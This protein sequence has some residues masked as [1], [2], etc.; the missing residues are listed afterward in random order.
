MNRRT[1]STWKVSVIGFILT[2]LALAGCGGGGGS[3]TS[4]MTTV[5]GSVSTVD[6]TTDAVV[7]VTAPTEVTLSIPA[8]TTLTDAS[9]NPVSGTVPTSVGYSTS[10]KDLPAAATTLPAG[11]ALAVF[12]DIRMGAVKYFS[13][14]VSLAIDVTS[15]GAIAGD[16]MVVYYFDSSTSQWRFG[17]TEIVDADGNISPTVTHLSVWAVFDSSTP[18]PVKPIG[19]TATAGTDQATIRWAAVNGVTSYNVY[20]GTSAGVDKSTASNVVTG[21]ADNACTVPNMING[22][23]YFFVVTAVDGNGESIESSEVSATPLAR[24]SGIQVTGGDSQVTCTWTAAAGA[25][26]YNVYY[27]TTT[28]QE[29]TASGVKDADASS[30]HVVI[31]LSNGTPYFFVVTAVNDSGESVVSA[32]K[33]AT[34]NAAPQ[35]PPSPTGVSVT[36]PSV[37]QLHASWNEVVGAT[38]YNVYFL[39]AASPPTKTDILATTPA[40]ATAAFLDA[41]GLTSGTPCYVLVTAVNDAGESGTQNSPKSVTIQ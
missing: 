37:G 10:A 35:P 15:S 31:D 39:Q 20:Y 14:P 6:G 11:S 3:S 25:T 33:T 28:G 18:P 40:S 30:P 19:V 23:A 27:S 8:G 36:S 38:S 13:N 1:R 41:T 5:T 22:T 4:I 34:P 17:G 12:V 29:T 16:A 26:S 9:S 7:P 21:V 32:E 24:P 2:G